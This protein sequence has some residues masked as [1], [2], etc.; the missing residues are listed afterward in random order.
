[1]PESLHAAKDGLLTWFTDVASGAKS[2]R[3]GLSDAMN[4]VRKDDV[5]VVWK[6]D[7][8]GRSLSRRK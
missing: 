3:P 8:L 7:R 2:D 1:M 5:L 6:L 4:F